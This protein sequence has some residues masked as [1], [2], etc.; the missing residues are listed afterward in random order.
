MNP[1]VVMYE[2]VLKL[3]FGRVYQ[4]KNI[5]QWKRVQGVMFQ[6]DNTDNAHAQTMKLKTLLG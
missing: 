3:G 4:T 5:G 2:H 1:F 6:L